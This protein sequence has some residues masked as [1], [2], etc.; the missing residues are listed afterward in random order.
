MYGPDILIIP[1][2]GE[3]QCGGGTERLG[4]DL[5]PGAGRGEP[6]RSENLINKISDQQEPSVRSH[7]HPGAEPTW[8]PL[9]LP[10]RCLGSHLDEVVLFVQ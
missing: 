9:V 10:Q 7:T 8:T 4:A 6:E 2:C 3:K 1:L 5:S